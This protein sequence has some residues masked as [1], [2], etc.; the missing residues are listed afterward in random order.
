MNGA[1]AIDWWPFVGRGLLA[2][3]FGVLALLR[4]DMAILTLVWLFG[5]LALLEGA[6]LL[7]AAVRWQDGIEWS[8]GVAGLL[9]AAVGVLAF[10]LPGPTALALVWLVAVW[11]LIGGVASIVAAVKLRRVIEGE[12]LLGLVGALSLVLAGF[13]LARPRIGA[14]AL[15]LALGVWAIV[16]GAVLVALGLRLRRILPARPRWGGGVSPAH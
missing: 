10:A 14:V 9:G 3:G 2:V 5:A 6:I 12:W 15:V 11:A 8:L 1:L 7:A 16:W 13:L 4:P